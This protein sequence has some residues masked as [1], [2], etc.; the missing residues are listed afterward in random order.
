MIYRL[1]ALCAFASTL[2]FG[3]RDFLTVD[4]S[5]QIR[6]SQEPNERLKL[7]LKFG[8][9]RI[10]MIKQAIAKE[11][12]GRS[13]LIHDTLE[14]YTNIIEAI[15]KVAEDALKRKV[16]IVEG[17]VVVAKAE[18]EMSAA[19]KKILDSTPKDLPRYEFALTIAIDTTN[20]SIELSQ[21]DIKDRTRD[22]ELAAAKQRKDR[23]SL[24]STKEIEEKKVEEKKEATTKKKAPSLRRKGE[25]VPDE[26][27]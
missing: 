11:K 17:M 21:T 8:R 13:G 1:L 23:D 16:D 24:L 2:A 26:K 7:Y 19:L 5:D 3:E 25:V 12:A 9:I 20:D 10:D 15:D 4:E 27:K 14:D 18:K 6:E 22:V